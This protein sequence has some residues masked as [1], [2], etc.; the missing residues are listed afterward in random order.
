MPPYP[1]ATRPLRAWERE[2]RAI[3]LT[4]DRP[5]RVVAYY[6][7]RLAAAGWKPEPQD[8]ATAVVDARNG[9]PVWIEFRR[10]GVGRLDLQ[11]TSGSRSGKTVT[12]I[13][14]EKEFTRAKL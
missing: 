11:V 5:D 13:F 8:A 10:S 3:A 1:G 4:G 6:L 7:G 14:Y 2:N 12:L 9:L